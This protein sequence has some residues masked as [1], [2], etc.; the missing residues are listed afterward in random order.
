MLLNVMKLILRKFQKFS[1]VIA[2]FSFGSTPMIAYTNY[3]E[4]VS[5]L[6]ER[7]SFSAILLT[8]LGILDR[9]VWAR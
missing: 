3:V 5:H 9:L 4:E 2:T 7:V 8:R 1:D 6:R